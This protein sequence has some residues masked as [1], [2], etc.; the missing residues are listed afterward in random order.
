MSIKSEMI[1]KEIIQLVPTAN[2]AEIKHRRGGKL[3]YPIY[4]NEKLKSVDLEVL[5]LSMRANNCLHR[6]GF[7]TIGDLVEKINGSEDLQ[8]IRNCGAKTIDEIMEK[9]F[10]YQYSLLSQEKKVK[11]INR[12]LELN[13]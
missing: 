11:Y 12:I 5:E 4:I 8:R 13:T 10:C 3:R 1:F 2:L 6:A 7:E 9:I